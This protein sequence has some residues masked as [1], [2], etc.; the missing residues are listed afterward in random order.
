M[1]VLGI[2]ILYF[3]DRNAEGL[4]KY[5][6]IPVV[7]IDKINEMPESD[8]MIVTPIARYDSIN[9]LLLSINPEIRTISI[10]EAV[11]EF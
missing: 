11:H 1:F 4:R 8:V 6:N 3:V 7:T 5:N 2:Q 10:Q 9:K